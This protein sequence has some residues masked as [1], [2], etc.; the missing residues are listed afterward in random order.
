MPGKGLC[1]ILLMTGLLLPWG[2]CFGDNPQPVPTAA[3]TAVASTSSDDKTEI[4]YGDLT[5]SADSINGNIQGL[6]QVTAKGDVEMKLPL[7]GTTGE[8]IRIIFNAVNLVIDPDPKPLASHS[9]SRTSQTTGHIITIRE[10]LLTT[11]AE[12]L[13]HRHYELYARKFILHPD[14]TFEA[15]KVSIFLYGHKLMVLSSIT[16]DLSNTDPDIPKP[17]WIV[18][19]TTADGAYAGAKFKM[20]MSDKDSLL[21]TARLGTEKVVRGELAV[22][23][24]VA[25]APYL[26]GTLAL[27]A[28]YREDIANPLH[29]S[30][31]LSL[32]RLPALQFIGKPV[33]FPAAGLQQASL[34]FGATIGRYHEEPTNVMENRATAWGILTSPRYRVGPLETFAGAGISGATAGGDLHRVAIG[35]LALESPAKSPV[36]FNLSL[37]RR[38]EAGQTPFLFDRVDIP[39]EL[40]SEIDFPLGKKSPW[41][42]DLANRQDM[43]LGRSRNLFITAIFGS[44]CFAYG[45][46]YDCIT[47]GFS[48]GI[49][50]N[51]FGTFHRGGGNIGFTQ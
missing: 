26:S 15:Q 25:P 20:A 19:K 38:S 33:V 3:P 40:Y 4:L 11:C 30:D 9:K 51:G 49:V 47:K 7:L 13:R 23:R 14:L 5:I 8:Q 46:T 18:G 28:S 35:Q 16:G 37:L 44:D 6:Q 32:S 34:R 41:R 1:I 27:L 45:L 31:T 48:A 42:F 43:E 22:S 21:M 12:P 29:A 24:P 2:R 17:H 50:L 36:Y 39:T 10:A